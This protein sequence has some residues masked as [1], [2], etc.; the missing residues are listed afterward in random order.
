MVRGREVIPPPQAEDSGLV[1]TTPLVRNLMFFFG[2]GILVCVPV[3]KTVT[4]LPP[5]MGILFGLG[6]LWLVGELIHRNKPDDD[7]NH[8]TLAHALVR[9]DMSSI[10]FFIGI[11][12]AVATLEHSHILGTLA[13]TLYQTIGRL[14]VI[15]TLIGLASAIVDN[16][17]NQ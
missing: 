6:I 15:V 17:I 7:K 2:L 5:F 9:I 11:L 8:L 13:K 3:F 1:Q 16:F 10:I 4:H 12:L 14:D